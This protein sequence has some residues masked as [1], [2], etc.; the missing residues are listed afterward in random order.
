MKKSLKLAALALGA[1]MLLPLAACGDDV[2][3]GTTEIS[4]W[5]DATI[6]ENK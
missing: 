5:Y 4:F 6:T 2:P 3:K 1:C